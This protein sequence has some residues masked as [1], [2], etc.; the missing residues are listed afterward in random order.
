M[1][2]HE[3]SDTPVELTV[4]V[5]GVGQRLDAYLAEHFPRHSRVQLRRTISAGGVAVDGKHLKAA[6]RLRLGERVTIVVPEV[7]RQR[8][9][10]ED[11]PLDILFEDDWLL[12]VNKPPGMVV[13]PARGHWKGTLASAVA[14]HCDQ[15]SSV[16]GPTRPGIVHRLDRDT[17]GVILVAKNDR[18]HLDLTSQF[19]RRTTEKE[20]L[21]IVIGAP[22]RDR[23]IIAQPIGVHPYQREKMAIRAGHATTRQAETFYEVQRR[24][25]GF[26]LIRVHPKT[27]R[28]HQIRLH[29]A[30]IGC[31]VLCDRLYGGRTQLTLG[32][33]LTGR[34]DDRVLL[35]RQALHAHRIKLVHPQTNAEIEFTAPLPDDL[36]AVLRELEQHRAV[37]QK[38]SG[39]FP[40][41]ES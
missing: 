33:V 5:A 10:P 25:R 31:P 38:G 7:P 22:D 6:Y 2:S 9:Q 39:L 4:D 23:D 41:K 16:G 8:P 27:G 15:L 35:A 18:A 3:L 34:E 26:A 17:S 40:G 13:H 1:A 19:E 12:V 30:H 21:A 37:S 14:H 20:Y 28:T 29:L 36:T 24:F 11:I 32:E